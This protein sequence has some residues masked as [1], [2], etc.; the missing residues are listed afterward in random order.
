[1]WSRDNGLAMRRVIRPALVIAAAGLLAGCFQPLYTER[2]LKG[3]TPVHEAM[4]SIDVDQIG[5]P[6]GTPQARVAEVLRN[7]LLFD[8]DGGEARLAP[9]HRLKINITM[10]RSAL[11]VDV[12]TGQ[13]EDEVTGID[14]SFTLTELS[15]GKVVVNGQT[16]SRVTSDVPGLEQRYALQR[17]ERDAENRAAKVVADQITLR[18]QSY[19]IAGT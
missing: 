15:T 17:G 12:A 16:F 18:L 10:S 3:G 9:T 14:A 13:T 8:L 7:D 1:M 19:L 11:I 4:R 2:T 5:A 6:R